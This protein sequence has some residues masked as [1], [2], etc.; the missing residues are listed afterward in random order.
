MARILVV[1]DDKAV[2]L[3]M[4]VVLEQEAFEVDEA[5]DGAQAVERIREQAPDLILCDIFMPKKD[6]FDT[7]RELRRIAAKIPIVAMS[8]SGDVLQLARKLGAM[9]VLYKP[10]SH[11][12]LVNAIRRSLLR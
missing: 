1:D 12:S 6:G 8:G 7:I 5:H 11:A 3:A 9:E 4:R 2:C 10:M